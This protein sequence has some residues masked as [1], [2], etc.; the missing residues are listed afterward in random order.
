V[1]TSWLADRVPS[2]AARR[3]HRHTHR[4][5]AELLQD[6]TASV[7]CG[8]RYR[9]QSSHSHD[10]SRRGAMRAQRTP[11]RGRIIGLCSAMMDAGDRAEG[12]PSARSRLVADGLH[13]STHTIALI[14]LR[15]GPTPSPAKHA[16]DARLQLRHRQAG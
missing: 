14:E 3:G 4:R 10:L 5:R 8:R 13:M 6:E 12:S 9:L 11:G 1:S 16:S 7:T 15:H 2:E